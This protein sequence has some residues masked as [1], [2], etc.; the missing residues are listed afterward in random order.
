MF[1][2]SKTIALYGQYNR[3]DGALSY[4]CYVLLM[5]VAMHIEYPKKASRVC[6][7]CI[8]SS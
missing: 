2:P 5:F 4:I 8:L 1:S 3:T 7:L 6:S